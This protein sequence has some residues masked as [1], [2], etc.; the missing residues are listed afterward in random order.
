MTEGKTRS[1]KSL[2]KGNHTLT[3]E[4]RH[5]AGPE[6][7]MGILGDG[8]RGTPTECSCTDITSFIHQDWG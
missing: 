5:Q 6:R 2:K 7:E 3:G 8:G 4:F 1:Y